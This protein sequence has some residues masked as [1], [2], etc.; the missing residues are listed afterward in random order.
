MKRKA[1][2]LTLLSLVSLSAATPRADATEKQALACPTMLH[3]NYVD[4][5]ATS[6]FFD[7]YG[8]AMEL[9]PIARALGPD[10]YFGI[11]TLIVASTCRDAPLWQV[12]FVWA[13]QTI[14]ANTHVRAGTARAG[15]PLFSF[16]VSVDSGERREVEPPPA[17]PEMER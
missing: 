7:V 10:L 13:A 14:A 9:N 5:V 1:A 17:M 2:V 11:V 12:V 16:V 6:H 4:W 15:V 3:A 8:P